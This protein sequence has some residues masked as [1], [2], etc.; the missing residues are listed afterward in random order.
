MQTGDEMESFA[1]ATRLT[2]TFCEFNVLDDLWTSR[3]T[4]HVPLKDVSGLLTREGS[5]RRSR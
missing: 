3:V 1:R 4:S 2:G 5:P